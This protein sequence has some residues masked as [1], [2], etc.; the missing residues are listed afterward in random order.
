MPVYDCKCLDCGCVSQYTSSVEQR[1]ILPFCDKCRG[2]TKKVIINAPRGYVKGNFAA[3]KS[4]VDGSLI[5]GDRTLRE[6]NLRNGVVSLHDGY[7]ES[8]VLAGDF[9][10]KEAKPDKKDIA[11]DIREAVQKLEYGGYKP[12]P[13]EAYDE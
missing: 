2:L 8:K 13:R 6:H 7:S 3:F 11:S 9:G 1:T 4:S 12:A 10:R 5:T